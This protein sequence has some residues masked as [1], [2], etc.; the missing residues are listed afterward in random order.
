MKLVHTNASRTFVNYVELITL[1][2][3]LIHSDEEEWSMWNAVGDPVLHIELRKWAHIGVILPLDANT[4]AKISNGICDNLLVSSNLCFLM[5][6]LC[7]EG[8]GFQHPYHCLSLY[9]YIHVGASANLKTIER[10][11]RTWI[12]SD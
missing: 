4:L 11:L 5:L 1:P 12:H 7:Y 8:M 2:N 6:D 10:H 9:E 3:T